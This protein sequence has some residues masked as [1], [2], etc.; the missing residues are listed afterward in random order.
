MARYLVTYHRGEMPTDPAAMEM[1]KAAFRA[2]LG[3]A[4]SAVVDPG[5]PVR[6]VGHVSNGNTASAEV[7][8]YT[9]IEAASVEDAEAVLRSHPF[10]ARG[11]AL[12][13]NEILVV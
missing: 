12:Q 6:K 9:I 11:G 1:V 10:V 5:A 13:I 4:G 2:W 3:E 7:G 8:G